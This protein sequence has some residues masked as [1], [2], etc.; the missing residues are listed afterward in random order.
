MEQSFV[1]KKITLT[2]HEQ[3]AFLEEYMTQKK[4]VSGFFFLEEFS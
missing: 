2:K 4:P 1:R 3:S